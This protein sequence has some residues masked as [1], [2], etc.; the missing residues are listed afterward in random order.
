M[1]APSAA[2]AAAYGPFNSP[3][4]IST[5]TA[6]SS[7]SAGT[8]APST[9]TAS[10]NAIA[11]ITSPAASGCVTIQATSWSNH[12][13]VIGGLYGRRGES[14]ALHGWRDARPVPVATGCRISPTW[15]P[16]GCHFFAFAFAFAFAVA[17]A[18]A[19]DL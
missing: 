4:P 5:P 15:Q 16:D 11:K 7:G 1:K 8:T 13:F 10:Q 12:P 14:S 3:S 18:V 17:V 9:I 2:H 6:N 19:A